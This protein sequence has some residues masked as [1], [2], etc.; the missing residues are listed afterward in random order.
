MKV[1]LGKAFVKMSAGFSMPGTNDI[2]SFLSATA[3]QMK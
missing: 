3:S 1:A 2:V